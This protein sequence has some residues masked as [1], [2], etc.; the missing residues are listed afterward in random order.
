[1][2]T[3]EIFSIININV[4]SLSIKYRVNNFYNQPIYLVTDNWFTFKYNHSLI[5]ISFARTK[6]V[7]GAKVFGYFLPILQII[8]PKKFIEKELLLEWP[9]KLNTIWNKQTYANPNKGHNKLK[10]II[11]YGLSEKIEEHEEFL[12]EENIQIWQKTA[13][14]KEYDIIV[15]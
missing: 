14:S 11:G 13:P 6:M 7:E 8:N 5:E 1:M 9:Q 3:V 15:K 12:I 2:V 10:I 4:N